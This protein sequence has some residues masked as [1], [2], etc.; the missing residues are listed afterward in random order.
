MLRATNAWIAGAAAVLC[1]AGTAAA[2]PTGRA[3]FVGHYYP[4][5]TVASFRVN[6]DGSL[7]HAGTVPSVE[8]TQ[9]IALSPDGRWLA[10]GAGSA[11]D[12]FEPLRIFR[13]N[14]DASLEIYHDT[15]VPDSPL[16][17]VWLA[18]DLLA[19]L[20][21]DTVASRLG[22]YRWFPET[23]QLVEIER[24]IVGGF[25]SHIAYHPGSEY[26]YTQVSTGS[27]EGPHI[28]RWRINPNGTL[29]AAGTFHTDCYPLDPV[30][31]PRGDFLFAGG[32]ISFGRHAV[33]SFLVSEEEG[34]LIPALGSP[35]TSPG[36]S[37]AFLAVMGD[38]RILAVG[39][40][41]DSTVRTFF[42]HPDGTLTDTG[43]SFLVQNLTGSIGEI[44]AIADVL[45]VTDD[46]SALD[47]VQGIYSLRVGA[48][49]SMTPL[50]PILDTGTPRP[51]GAIAV[52]D[53]TRLCP[54]DFDGNSVVNSADISAFLS[55]WLEDVT[56]GGGYADFDASGTTNSSDISA[57]LSRWLAAVTGNCA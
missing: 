55:R 21:T 28:R 5:G 45:Y 11:A 41:T 8:W 36:N 43:H 1:A 40:G 48:D 2:Q 38:G 57:F 54:A 23:P 49:G 37:P 16:E 12:T 29:E 20:E 46:T 10:A 26:V 4:Q 25:T 13:V 6:A 3:V 42:I 14:A 47:G 33:L 31:S 50:G 52:W 15:M 24:E 56:V 44:A 32:G 51:E 53:P 18:P 17:M 34:G 30:F 9:S 7:T 39:H 19:V 27:L 35:F 22:I